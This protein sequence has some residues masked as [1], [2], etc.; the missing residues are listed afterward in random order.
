[1]TLVRDFGHCPQQCLI[2]ILSGFV[3][4][5]P[6]N[7]RFVEGHV[8]LWYT[9]LYREVVWRSS[10][11]LEV[12]IGCLF[13]S[14]NAVSVKRSGGVGG[15]DILGIADD[16][17]QHLRHVPPLETY[18]GLLRL[19]RI[20]QHSDWIPRARKP[21][22]FSMIAVCPITGVGT[23]AL[24]ECRTWVHKCFLALLICFAQYSF[25]LKAPAA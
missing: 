13:N 17:R 25:Q 15:E 20:F 21:A 9:F 3:S 4:C 12:K 8:W 23:Y 16:I 1:M 14:C 5:L 2:A 10:S 7:P 22:V 24:L 6:E 11:R 18:F 19:S